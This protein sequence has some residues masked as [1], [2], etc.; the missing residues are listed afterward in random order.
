M[1]AGRQMGGL[2]L[3]IGLFGVAMSPSSASI[4]SDK[5]RVPKRH[6]KRIHQIHTSHLVPPHGP[7]CLR[8]DLTWLAKLAL[9]KQTSQLSLVMQ[10]CMGS[11]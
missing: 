2:Y 1:C 8:H 11:V 9:E 5:P 10:R 4:G 3:L 7:H 6:H